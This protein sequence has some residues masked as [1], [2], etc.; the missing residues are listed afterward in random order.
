MKAVFILMRMIDGQD[1]MYGPR[2]YIC[3]L[4]HEIYNENTILRLQLLYLLQYCLR[5]MF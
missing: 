1:M 4:L 3:S 2:R 5:R